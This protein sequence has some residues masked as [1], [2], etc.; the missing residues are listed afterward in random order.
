MINTNPTDRHYWM[1]VQELADRYTPADLADCARTDAE[2]GHT[3]SARI[4]A[5]AAVIASRIDEAIEE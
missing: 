4:Y 5:T 2:N 1:Q 3:N